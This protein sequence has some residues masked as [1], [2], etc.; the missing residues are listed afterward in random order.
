[1]LLIPDPCDGVSI[2]YDRFI[3]F[4]DGDPIVQLALSIGAEVTES[5]KEISKTTSVVS[6]IGIPLS[7]EK[8][9]KVSDS[10]IV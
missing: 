9:A 10:D 7:Q 4:G 8:S 1:L 6:V 2:K 5:I 3:G